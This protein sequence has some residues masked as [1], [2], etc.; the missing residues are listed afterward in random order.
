MFARPRFT[1]AASGAFKTPSRDRRASSRSWVFF[2]TCSSASSPSRGRRCRAFRFLGRT[3]GS[4]PSA[5]VRRRAP[6]R[7]PP[8]AAPPRRPTRPRT[9]RR[10][11]R[12]RTPTRPEA[13]ES[14]PA[15]E[16]TKETR[17]RLRR[18]RLP[19]ETNPR[20]RIRRIRRIRRRRRRAM[21][22][23]RSGSDACSTRADTSTSACARG[24]RCSC[25]CVDRDWWGR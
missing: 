18:R 21:R 12:R 25:P 6:T 19:S 3:R 24:A 2:I 20:R 17:G 4:P 14:D 15:E 23:A 8:R 7:T 10:R 16:T 5:P 9:P 13:D 22:R 11:T 1:A